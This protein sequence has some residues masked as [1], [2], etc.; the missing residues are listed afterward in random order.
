[1]DLS[2]LNVW[3]NLEF[4]QLL[5]KKKKH[6]KKNKLKSNHFVKKCTTMLLYQTGKK[7]AVA[8]NGVF[9][10]SITVG[11]DDVSFM[12]INNKVAL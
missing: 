2:L 7:L 9:S 12:A 6:T 10:R 3:N 11:N 1:M 4:E 8:L 5:K